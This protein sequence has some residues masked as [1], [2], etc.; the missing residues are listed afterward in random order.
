[1]PPSGDR[2]PALLRNLDF[3]TNDFNIRTTW[4]PCATVTLVGR[5]DFQLSTIDNRADYLTEVQA[6]EITTHILSGSMT[7]TPIARLYVRLPFTT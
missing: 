5:Y 2:Y 6:G 4:R 3:Q 7:W 1:M